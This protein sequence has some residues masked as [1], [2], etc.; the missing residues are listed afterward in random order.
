MQI[1]KKSLIFKDAQKFFQIT[2]TNS[3]Q[4]LATLAKKLGRCVERARPYYNTCK[5]AEEVFFFNFN[6]E[7]ISKIIHI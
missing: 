7:I 6:L 3:K 4:R 2:F 1:R 5:Q